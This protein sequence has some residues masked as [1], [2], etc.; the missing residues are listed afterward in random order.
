MRPRPV[1]AALAVTTAAVITLG[2]VAR[3][4]A[5]GHQPVPTA[6]AAASTAPPGPEHAPTLEVEAGM[7]S[8]LNG[9]GTRHTSAGAV[10]RNPHAEAAYGVD[11]EFNLKDPSGAVLDSATETVNYLP[12]HGSRIVAPLQIGFD[13]AGDAESVQVVTRVREFAPDVGPSGGEDIFRRPDGARLDVVDATLRADDYV[14]RVAGLVVN[15]TGDVAQFASLHCVLRA[16][17]DIVGG[18]STGL[19]TPIPPG[20]TASFESLLTVTPD[21]VDEVDC[22][23]HAGPPGPAAG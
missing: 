23:V 7:S 13:V 12:A 5:A 18:T 3:G 4:S 16:D 15:L 17:E 11:V 2:S 10:L 22:E 19:T 8:E 14:S 1:M 6:D 21:G 9:V 20:A